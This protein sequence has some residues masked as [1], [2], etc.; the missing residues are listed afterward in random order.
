LASEIHALF[1]TLVIMEQAGAPVT[2]E[3]GPASVAL[4]SFQC[5]ERLG[6]YR[7][8]REIGRGGMGVVFEAEQESL[9]RRVALKV[10]PFHAL[11][12]ARHLIRFQREA[13]A[14]AQLHH[15]HIV[16]VFG[17]GQAEGVYFYAML[18][19]DNYPSA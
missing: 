5:P 12:D 15:S 7:I 6:E 8:L 14:A 2:S 18:F 10:F 3:A 1:P 16:P 17:V 13:R 9:A 19:G 4:S 11:M